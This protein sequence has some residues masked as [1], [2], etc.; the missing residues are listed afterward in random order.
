MRSFVRTLVAALVAL[1]LA[2][3]AV[4]QEKT[5]PNEITVGVARLTLSMAY[6]SVRVNGEEWEHSYFEEDGQLLILE[7]MN[8]TAEVVLHLVPM[9]EEF[10]FVDV[11][12]TP[13]DWKLARLDRQTR[14]WQ[15]SKKITFGKWKPGE[16]EEWEK[17]QGDAAEEPEELPPEEPTK[18]EPK[19]SKVDAAPA[20]VEEAPAEEPAEVEEAPTGEPVD[21][22][23]GEKPAEPAPEKPAE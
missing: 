13:R 12:V 17:K 14:Q 1:A 22:K 19:P 4:A 16:R 3:P 20:E 18:P 10:R 11:T 21:E 5:D 8:R 7:G 2:S 6:A 15:F 9:E 23:P